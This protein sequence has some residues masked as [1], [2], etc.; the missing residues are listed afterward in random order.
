MCSI[1]SFESP[2]VATTF[3]P[4][5]DSIFILE[6]IPSNKPI[7]P[8]NIPDCIAVIVFDPITLCGLFMAILGSLAVALSKASID[9]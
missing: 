7:Y 1:N 6:I 3:I 2:P 4:D 5:P 8:Q 9:K